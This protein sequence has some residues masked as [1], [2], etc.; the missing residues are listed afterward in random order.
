M[1]TFD[2][3]LT[4]ITQ[5]HIM[6]K[7]IDNVLKSTVASVRWLSNGRAW[8]GEQ[9]KIP[10]KNAKNTSSG[11]FGLGDTFVTDK[12]STRKLLKFDPKFYY[13]NVSLFGPE[14]DVNAISE[15]QVVNLVKTEMQSVQQDAMEEVAGLMYGVGTGNNPQ[16]LQGIIDDGT[17]LATY[18]EQTRSSVTNLNSNVNTVSG[19]LTLALMA[20]QQSNAKR[21][22]MKPTI[23]LTT[24][25]LF[26]DLEEL[27]QP[28]LA[29][30][31]SVMGPHKVTSRATVMPGQSLGPAQAGFD[32]IMHRG[33]PVAGDE[34]CNSGE[35]YFINETFLQW[36]G[37]KSQWAKPISLASDTIEGPYAADVPSKNHGFNWTGFK[38][39][40]NQYARNGQILLLGNLISG[41]PRYNSK[42][43]SLT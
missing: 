11:T 35:M 19:P 21:G 34:M 15:S 9:L 26:D 27:L 8:M 14:V 7:V 43:E 29:A 30:N 31:Y 12:V 16:G 13:A 20:A 2:E 23:I 17:F 18:G 3:Y 40:T 1:A 36:Y 38:E 6:P 37:L 42:L 10:F 28:Q 22:S 24:E 32:A 5:D 4:S 33:V 41:G 25:S 39:P